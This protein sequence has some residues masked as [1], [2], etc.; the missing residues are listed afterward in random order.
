MMTNCNL[1]PRLCG[2]D[3]SGGKAGYCRKTDEI[4]IARAAL[5][6]W[7]EPCISG[8]DGSGTVF[9]SGCNLRCIYCQNSKIAIGD[10]GKKI[11]PNE[12]SQIFLDLQSQGANN[13]NLVTPT[14]YALQIAQSLKLAKSMG[15]TLPIVYNTGG[16]ELPETLK[17]LEGLVDIYM[18]DFKYWTEKTSN[19]YSN[20]PDYPQRAKAAIA[21][22]HRQCPKGEYDSRGIMKKGLIVR[23]MLIPEHVYEAKRIMSFLFETYGNSIVYSIMSQYTPM[24]QFDDF[25][26]LNRRVRKKEYDSLVDF[27]MELGIENAY[28]QDGESAK[29][30]FIPEF[31]A[32]A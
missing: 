19:R 17:S 16:Y 27:C 23:H 12:L 2:A 18:P 22:M 5:H 6:Y 32:P 24:A 14:H 28:I 21:E 10:V 7:E 1:C 3:R 30:S 20:A 29:E 26:E 11:T 25:P 4:Y 9:F 8:E 13:I 15:L 31:I